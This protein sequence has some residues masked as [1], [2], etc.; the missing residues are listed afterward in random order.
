[1]NKTSN[2]NHILQAIAVFAILLLTSCEHKDLCYDHSHNAKIRVVFD[3]KN[4]PDATPETM[5]LYLFPMDGGRPQAY[6]FTDYRGGYI[7]IP[8]GRYRVLCVNSDTESVLFRNI[9]L[10]DRFEA[11]AP[12]GVLNVRSSLAPR[13]E[14]TSA[15]HVVKSPDRLYSARLDDVMIKLSNENQTVT[16]YPELSVCRYRVTITNVSNLKYISSDGISGALSGMSGG[17]LVGRNELTTDPVTVPFGVSSDGNSILTADFLAFGQT[18]STSPAHKL[19]IY[20]IMSDGSKNYYTFDVTRQVDDA[21][22]PRD[23]H[24]ILDGLP[25]PKPIVNGGGFHPA[26]D[27]WQNVDVEVPM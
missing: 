17:L 9:D 10:F 1:M 8:A 14:G 13:A 20:V 2:I 21:T 15:E 23:V 22:D 26:V 19:V 11:Y 3:W 5:R 12:D 7:I 16:L 24:I 6:E 18:G 25:L 4:A 27:E